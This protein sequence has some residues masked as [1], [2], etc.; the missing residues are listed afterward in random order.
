VTTSFDVEARQ[1]SE[2]TCALIEDRLKDFTSRPDLLNRHL[3]AGFLARCLA[4]LRG[5]ASLGDGG[6]D[7]LCGVLCRVLLEACLLG[8]YVLLGGH[9]ALVEVMGDYERNVKMLAE[10]N[11]YEALNELIADTDMVSQRVNLEQVAKK[12]GPLLEAAGDKAADAT[13]LYDAVYRSQSTFHIHGAGAALRYLSMEDE[14]AWRI[15]LRPDPL[16]MPSSVY[17][18]LG[19]L[20]VTYFARVAF[21]GWGYS[22][23]IAADLLAR[24]A[25][26]ADLHAPTSPASRN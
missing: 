13:G 21:D 14:V 26:V 9:E 12:L 17:S 1:L 20:Y 5:I 11:D 23:E 2:E 3:S 15:T 7:D 25:V 22:A 24:I 19:A 6:F 8:L 18:I 10:R 4:L 16:G